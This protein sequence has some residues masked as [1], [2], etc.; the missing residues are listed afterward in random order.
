VT[1]QQVSSFSLYEEMKMRGVNLTWYDRC[2]HPKL[3]RNIPL[4][5]EWC[6][7]AEHLPAEAGRIAVVREIQRRGVL[8]GPRG[9]AESAA[10]CICLRALQATI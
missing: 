6:S 4:E 2:K 5:S 10:R 9:G 7:R 8:Q 1:D 3:D